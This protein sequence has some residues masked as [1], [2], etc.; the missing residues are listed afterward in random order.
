M[1]KS[2]IYVANTTA[3]TVA[4]NGTIALGST[5]R[6]FGCATMLSGNTITLDEAGYYDVDVS[7]TASP[8]AI[9][10]VTV[11]LLN[12]GVPVQGATASSTVAVANTPANVSFDGVVRVFCGANTGALSLVLLGTESNVTNVAVVVTKL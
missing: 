6:R 2:A 11:S 10:T 5:I 7:V 3:Q 9:G 1:S 12:N 8:T 4:V